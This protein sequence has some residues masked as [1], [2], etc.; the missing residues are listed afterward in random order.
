[1]KKAELPTS[2]NLIKGDSGLK[3]AKVDSRIPRDDWTKEELLRLLEALTKYREN[4]DLIAHHVETRSKAECIMQFMKLPFGDQF[5]ESNSLDR[6]MQYVMQVAKFP[7][8]GN[9]ATN[10]RFPKLV[11]I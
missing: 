7:S 1:M 8:N 6:S 5:I 2:D 11:K 10:W 3:E 4:W 9:F